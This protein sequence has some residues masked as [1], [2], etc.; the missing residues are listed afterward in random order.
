MISSFFEEELPLWN[1]S[2]YQRVTVILVF[3]C[4][5]NN[6]IDQIDKKLVIVR[7]NSQ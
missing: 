3:K 1:M 5:W 2:T 7:K 6:S 4:W